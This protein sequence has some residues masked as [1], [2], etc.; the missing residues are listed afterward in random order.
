[1]KA[2]TLQLSK[3]VALGLLAASSYVAT[4]ATGPFKMALPENG[5]A[6]DAIKAGQYQQALEQIAHI[7][8]DL[9]SK[10]ISLCVAHTQLSQFSQAE[11]A[12]S[13]AIVTVR[14]L[15]GESATTKREMRALAFS[16]RGVTRLLLQDPVAALADFEQADALS[17]TAISQYNLELLQQKLKAAVTP[18]LT[19][20]R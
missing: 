14:R 5:P 2:T 4:A 19:A 6:A 18:V 3:M 12:C 16:N 7:D 10:Q 8:S 11:Q 15:E 13:Q 20:A 9:F 17:S 1:M